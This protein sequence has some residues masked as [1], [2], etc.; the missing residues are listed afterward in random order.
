MLNK[1]DIVKLNNTHFSGSARRLNK[2]TG[3]GKVFP[4][5]ARVATPHV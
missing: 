5:T 4:L 1:T 3:L 2:E